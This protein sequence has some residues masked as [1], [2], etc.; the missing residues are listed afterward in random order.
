M[1]SSKR[2]IKDLTV[3]TLQEKWDWIR[4]RWNQMRWNFNRT[5][6]EQDREAVFFTRAF[7][8]AAE[9]KNQEVFTFIL[10]Q[11]GK[12]RLM[13]STNP[14]RSLVVRGDLET[15]TWMQNLGFGPH[16][17]LAVWA[18]THGKLDIFHWAMKFQ[19]QLELGDV[20]FA[21]TKGNHWKL[22][23]VAMNSPYHCRWGK[24][25]TTE[26]VRN[27]NIKAFI[28]ARQ[29]NLPVKFQ[30]CLA[31]AAD[32]G[33]LN[34]LQWIYKNESDALENV[35]YWDMFCM[36]NVHSWKHIPL[37]EWIMT[38]TQGQLPFKSTIAR[39]ATCLADFKLLDWLHRLPGF[40]GFTA[41][42]FALAVRMTP[43]S[44]LFEVLQWLR[45]H[46]CPW[47]DRVYVEAARRS[48]SMILVWA[49]TQQCPF[50]AKTYETLCRHSLNPSMSCIALVWLMAVR[51]GFIREEVPAE[52]EPSPTCQVRADVSSECRKPGELSP[53]LL[54]C[55]RI[56]AAAFR[57]SQLL[58]EEQYQC[59]LTSLECT[60]YILRQCK[61]TDPLQQSEVLEWI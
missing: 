2:Y 11:L 36:P 48:N 30:D 34:I 33:Q 1:V 28:W 22:A 4:I 8:Q 25:S 18:A 21:A 10:S 49:W 7:C 45:A 51:A 14:S 35:L 57:S 29:Q 37:Y 60:N 40:A 9:E 44:D 23:Q 6:D 46:G 5:P 38:T 47:D 12:Q 52:P 19:T 39:M 24:E 32:R 42:D 41:D 17:L 43:N 54:V 16:P 15:L 58:T 13:R 61:I 20:C 55:H 53:F 27:G 26:L 56:D 3:E 59:F 50:T 31:V